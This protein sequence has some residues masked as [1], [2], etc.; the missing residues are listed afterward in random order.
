[1]EQQEVKHDEKPT[2]EP[3]TSDS[4]PMGMIW[5][6]YSRWLRQFMQLRP[7]IDTLQVNNNPYLR[8]GTCSYDTFL[9]GML[10]AH[11]LGVWLPTLLAC[12][13]KYLF[14]KVWSPS[15][16]AILV[17]IAIGLTHWFLLAFTSYEKRLQAS[18]HNSV[19]PRL[20][21][22]LVLSMFCFGYYIC[23]FI[24]LEKLRL[25]LFFMSMA[26]AYGQPMEIFNE[27]KMAAAVWV[28]EQ[29]IVLGYNNWIIIGKSILFVGTTLLYLL[30]SIR[31]TD[32]LPPESTIA[33]AQKQSYSTIV[34]LLLNLLALAPIALILISA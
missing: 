8:G 2:V 34:L 7:L 22:L 5:Q 13:P 32:A 23:W 11:L 31:S 26:G 12:V 18:G 30:P 9:S 6:G 14:P 4:S 25:A 24:Q 10:R 3:Q 20:V 27:A 28:K 33:I 19:N 29:F 1:M 21:G 17:V 16:N 15:Q